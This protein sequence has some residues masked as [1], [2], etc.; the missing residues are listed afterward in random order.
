MLQFFYELKSLGIHFTLAQILVI[1]TET[2]L[3]FV[4]IV[5]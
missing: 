1:L 3:T 4:K 5:N 2:E